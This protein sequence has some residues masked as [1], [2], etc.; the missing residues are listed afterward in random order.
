MLKQILT[1]ACLFALGGAGA[2]AETA[3]ARTQTLVYSSTAEIN[4]GDLNAFLFGNG[5]PQSRGLI[6]TQTAAA[7]VAAAPAPAAEIVLASA[8]TKRV[9][10][11][12][13]ASDAR[14]VALNIQFAYDSARVPGAAMRQ[15]AAFAE[16]LKGPDATAAQITIAGHTDTTGDAAYNMAL[17]FN[18][19]A[20][21]RA[22][23]VERFG[24][25]GERLS[26]VG[27]GESQPLDAIHGEDGRNRRVEFAVAAG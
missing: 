2:H 8:E 12:A 13:P 21:V 17:S 9:E 16:A 14:S 10:T 27:R 19:A 7:P 24:V 1:A 5:K 23:L 25:P 15:L 4:A 6:M 18:R 20:A 26:A 3:P 22:I 11:P